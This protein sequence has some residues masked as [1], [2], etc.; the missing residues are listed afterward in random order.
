MRYTI[1]TISSKAL[2]PQIL[3]VVLH[4]C[5]GLILGRWAVVDVVIF[6]CLIE[7]EGFVNFVILD[8]GIIGM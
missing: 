3:P 8:I 2:I 7:K 4:K 6:L 1:L 5:F